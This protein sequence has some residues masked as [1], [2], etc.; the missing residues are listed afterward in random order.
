MRKGRG[1]AQI[2]ESVTDQA[3]PKPAGHL[4][5]RPSYNALAVAAETAEDEA[6]L[7]N[8]GTASV[9]GAS[10]PTRVKFDCGEFEMQQPARPFHKAQRSEDDD[11]LS[12]SRR[13]D[14]VASCASEWVV[15]GEG[16]RA[17]CAA[18]GS[19]HASSLS[20]LAEA[21]AP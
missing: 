13:A 12:T 1:R 9:S 4:P 15:K 16:L 8:H 11:M 18:A 7:R 6:G 19:S 14:S 3:A 17:E 5:A 21:A 20:H 10:S 2:F